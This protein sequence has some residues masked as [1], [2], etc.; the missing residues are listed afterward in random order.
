LIAF[1]SYKNLATSRLSGLVDTYVEIKM[2]SLHMQRISDIALTPAAP[3]DKQIQTLEQHTTLSSS[4]ILTANNLSFT[5]PQD[6]T[7]LF[8]N[9]KIEV[10]AGEKVAIVGQSGIGKSTLL[11]TLN[12][13]LPANE[14]VVCIASKDI[15]NIQSKSLRQFSATIMQNDTLLTGTIAE[16]IAN[17][18]S[19][20]DLEKVTECAQLA[21]IN[22]D[23]ENMPMQLNTFIGEMGSALSGGQ[24]QRILL[25]RAL[26]KS[27]K[28]LFLD[29]ATSHL[30]SSTER[31][32]I[33]NFNQLNIAQII[34]AHRHET[35]VN[36][37]RVLKL[38]PNGL[39]DVTENYRNTKSN[40]Q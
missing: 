15:L 12:R 11:Q 30:D 3:R 34:I 25:A 22:N 38:T 4:P 9:I 7:P 31:Q 13:L 36:A 16:N 6:K 32:V 40:T 39:E 26:Y 5:Y 10:N 20:I 27:P 1:V 2:L 29:E 24:I 14:G 19:P 33:A 28:L 18:K 21:C 37:D 35:I 8:S 23:I 17:F